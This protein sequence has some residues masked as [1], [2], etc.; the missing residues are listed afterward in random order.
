MRLAAGRHS[1]G[2]SSPRARKALALDDLLA[3]SILEKGPGRY[4]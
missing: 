4:K 3:S 1:A 2:D